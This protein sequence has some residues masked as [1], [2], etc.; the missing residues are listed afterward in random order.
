MRWNVARL[1]RCGREIQGLR[2][3]NR[4]HVSRCDE[5]RTSTAG[6]D[7]VGARS[8]PCRFGSSRSAAGLLWGTATQLPGEPSC[9]EFTPRPIFSTSWTARRVRAGAP[10]SSKWA[11]AISSQGYHQVRGRARC[12]ALTCRIVGRDDLRHFSRLQPVLVHRRRRPGPAARGW[13]TATARHDVGRFAGDRSHGA[14]DTAAHEFFTLEHQSAS[15][16]PGRAVRLRSREH[17]RFALAR[18]SFTEY[19]GPSRSAEP[20]QPQ[21]FAAMTDLISEVAQP[22]HRCV[23]GR[24]GRMAPFIDGGRPIDRTNWAR[25]VALLSVRRGHRAC[26]RPPPR[27]IGSD[28]ARHFMKAMW[29]KFGKPGGAR[30][31]FVDHPYSRRRGGGARRRKNPAFA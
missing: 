29:T 30:Q 28:P 11:T 20:D 10:S 2:R 16:Q 15:G 13:S 21:T 14:P 18:R 25:T 31:G 9:R 6:R 17:D 7:H 8:R 12:L 26:A 5:T 27:S 24:D 19:H 4:R 1:A 3:S 23:G 22:A